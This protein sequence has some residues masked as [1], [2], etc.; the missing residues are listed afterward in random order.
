MRIDTY[1]PVFD[2]ALETIQKLTRYGNTR[3]IFPPVKKMGGI[4]ADLVSVISRFNNK[5]GLR[6]FKDNKQV[7]Q[8]QA[9][10]YH[11][12]LD[13]AF[14]S[15]QEYRGEKK[16][17]Y[18]HSTE[19]TFIPGPAKATNPYSVSNW[20][21]KRKMS[22]SG[23]NSKDD[24]LDFSRKNPFINALAAEGLLPERKNR[25]SLSF[26]YGGPFSFFTFL[27]YQ[28]YKPLLTSDGY[29][30]FP[31]SSKKEHFTDIYA[32]KFISRPVFWFERGMMVSHAL[33]SIAKNIPLEKLIDKIEK[34]PPHQERLI[35][36]LQE[37]SLPLAYK[38][39]GA[40]L[41]G[42][43]F[44]SEETIKFFTK[45]IPPREYYGIF[46]GPIGR[47]ILH[48]TFRGSQEFHGSQELDNIIKNYNQN[49]ATPAGERRITMEDIK[50]ANSI[51]ADKKKRLGA[52]NNIRKSQEVVIPP[53]VSSL[54]SVN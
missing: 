1:Q 47:S 37:E 24:K 43:E 8:S 40:Y 53:H 26:I 49:Y 5:V 28:D 15:S 51:Q 2:I 42:M 46:L 7:F 4:A 45:E 11:Y 10:S 31:V 3:L 20:G 13:I 17:N 12:Y 23:V 19:I 21:T 38:F 33:D 6:V 35:K 41:K 30:L 18:F 34:S 48:F 27:S 9:Y 14:D 32:F 54:S 16:D 44:K 25:I 39:I 50:K 29:S 52:R 22:V 36:E